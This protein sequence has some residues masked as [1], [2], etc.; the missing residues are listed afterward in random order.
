[1]ATGARRGAAQKR[2]TSAAKGAARAGAAKRTT[3][4]GAT[5]GAKSAAKRSTKAGAAKGAKGAGKATKSR[6][7][8]PA[9]GRGTRAER[10]E[11]RRREQ[12]RRLKARAGNRYLVHYDIDGP[13]V[14][15]GV[16]WFV[17]S[18]AAFA[19]G[20][21][22][23]ALWF[24]VAFGAAG[25]HTLRTWRARGAPVDPRVALLGVAVVVAGAAVHPR[26]MGVLLLALVGV[27]VALGARQLGEGD[28]PLEA[29]ARASLVLQSALP[30]AIAGGCLVL[31]ADLEVWAAI[32]LVL[33]A[34]A[35]E[36]GDYLIGS[37]A[38]NAYEGPLAGGLA[39]FVVT[40]VVAALGFPPFDVGEA[41]VFG[42]LVAPGAFAGQL[43]ASAL[44]PH[45]RAFAPALRRVDSLLLVTPLWYA[46]IDL[47]VL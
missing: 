42:L 5:K 24:A 21:P 36:S 46:G 32:S 12:A 7:A 29:L 39:V 4:A 37:G 18:L 2:A 41:M 47:V 27:A 16:A 9:K 31:L 45:A 3:K 10:A 33:L 6:R 38:A 1:M 8:A 15:L 20:T 23:T 40:L 13:R 28:Q 35:Y 17:G 26:A 44:L 11:A 25:S 19:L 22:A 34:S 30:P 14:R 43:L